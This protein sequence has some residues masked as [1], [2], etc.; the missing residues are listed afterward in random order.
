KKMS[1]S[2]GNV[3]DPWIMIE[4]YGVD[5]LRLW[6]YSVNQPGE[7]KNFDEKTVVELHRQVFGLLYNVLAF[8]ELYRDKD[9]EKEN[10]VNS[11]NI[12]DQ[13]ILVRFDELVSICTENMDKFRPLES[14]RAIK[15]FIGDLS[16]WYLRRSRD[17]IKEG[18]KEA[19]QTLYFVLKNL[20]KIMA[21]FAPFSADDIWLKLKNEADLESVHLESWPVSNKINSEIL[22]D[23]E[24]VRKIVSLG[25]EARQKAGI[26][27]RQP[28]SRIEVKDYKLNFEYSELIKDELNVKEISENSKI[29]SEV[30]LDIEITEEL[31]EEGSYRELVRAIQDMRKKALLTPSDVISLIVESNDEAKKLIQKFETEIKKTA[32]VS[33][34]EFSANGGDE[35][36]VD[37]LAFKIKIVK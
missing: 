29:E 23:M 19:K 11:K 24:E 17:R 10:K 21:P 6:M 25:L 31:K 12:L 5:T 1:K 8:Y 14:T 33:K 4:K 37:N 36:K 9:L 35:I 15:D 13:W 2:I 22:K 18:D 26:K 16:T 3:I 32:L 30:L 27:V 34:I 28:L 20:A 7:S